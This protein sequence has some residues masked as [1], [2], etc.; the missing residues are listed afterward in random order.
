MKPG[1]ASQNARARRRDRASLWGIGLGLLVLLQP[2]W[3]GGFL[4]GFLLTA[5]ATAAQIVASHALPRDSS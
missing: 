3:E 2:W 1:A 4:L 5:A